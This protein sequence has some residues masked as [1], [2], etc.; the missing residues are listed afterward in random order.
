MAELPARAYETP[1]TDLAAL[2]L[3]RE[4]AKG[5]IRYKQIVAIAT[6]A[7]IHQGAMY[8]AKHRLGIRS[9]DGVWRLR[10]S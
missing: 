9:K 3:L 6:A 4:L 1:A 2:L 10:E 5:P 7:G 8:R